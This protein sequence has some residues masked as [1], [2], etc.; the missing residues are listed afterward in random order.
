MLNYSI[1]H[2]W[3]TSTPTYKLP[4][5]KCN[6]Q[7]IQPRWPLCNFLTAATKYILSHAQIQWLNF[8]QNCCIF[9]KTSKSP[10]E[11]S[12][13]IDSSLQILVLKGDQETERGT[14]ALMQK[15]DYF[16]GFWGLQQD[17]QHA[18][19]GDYFT[20]TST[21]QVQRLWSES[22]PSVEGVVT[23]ETE[24]RTLQEPRRSISSAVMY[25]R[26]HPACSFALTLPEIIYNWRQE[27]PRRSAPEFRLI[28]SK[29]HKAVSRDRTAWTGCKVGYLGE[30][31]PKI[32]WP[33]IFVSLAK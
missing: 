19:G 32:D 18:Q 10:L 8:M 3:K 29:S 5:P 25:C 26:L 21:T 30:S 31:T 12:T 15:S 1:I 27:V 22:Q 2:K 7:I 33:N 13:Y 6:P 20:G 24:P 28:W 9:K 14:L 17:Q 16:M 4:G 11:E 23:E